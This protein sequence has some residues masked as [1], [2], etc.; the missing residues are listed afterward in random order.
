MDFID[1]LKQFSNR[2]EQLKSCINTEEATKTSIIMPFFQLLGYDI[3]NP[4]E[5]IPEFTADVGVKKGEKVDYAIVK[6]GQPIILI[7]AK[8]CGENLEKHD[9]QLFRYFTTT[10]AKFGILTDGILYKFFTDLDEQNVMDEKPFLEFNLLDIKDNTVSEIKKFKKDNYDLETILDT[11][12]ELKYSNL[13]KQYI[14][15]QMLTPSDTFIIN[16]LSEVYE[17]KKTQNIINKFRDVVKKSLNQ[18]INELM[19]ERIKAAIEKQSKN[20]DETIKEEQKEETS[21]IVLSK[22]VTTEEELEGFFIIKSMLREII[23]SDRINY[24]DT[25]S[26]FGIILDNNTR[27]WICRLQLDGSQ[28]YMILRDNTQKSGVKTP[29]SNIEDLYIYRDLLVEIVKEI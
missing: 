22:I 23:S 17:G 7:E 21:K 18:Y 19:N 10:K 13:I 15:L 3:F 9:S 12:S 25:E 28:K 5:F 29:I 8:C 1:E 20:D 26:Y 16:I 2:V 4:A 11:A 24:K 6:D 14:S 27:K